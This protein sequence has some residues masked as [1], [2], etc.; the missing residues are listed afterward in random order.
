M[1]S[2]TYN[3][4]KDLSEEE[5]K[6]LSISS[7]KWFS[8]PAGISAID[9]ADSLLLT[10]DQIMKIMEGFVFRGLGTINENVELYCIKLD[11]ENT[12][13]DFESKKV[14][15]HIFF[16]SKEVLKYYFYKSKLAKEDISEYVK[17]LHLGG[18]Q[19]SLSFFNEEVLRKYFDH[20]ELYEIDD[21]MAG[22][23][24]CTNGVAEENEDEYIHVRYGKKKINN[25]Y[26]AITAILSD[27]AA[28]SSN[29]QKYW[30]S[31]EIKECILDGKDEN[32]NKF[33]ERNFEGE[34]V[35]YPNPINDVTKVLSEYNRVF[36]EPT[37]YVQIENIHLRPP[38]ENT[39]KELCN[40][41]SELYKLIGPDNIN[42][43]VLKEYLKKRFQY[44]DSA[45][46]HFESQKALSVLQIFKLFEESITSNKALYE[47]IEIIK[48]YR[49]SA[50]HKILGKDKKPE[51]YTMKF[52]EICQQYV[53]KANE[54]LGKII[55]IE[56]SDC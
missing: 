55:A 4:L 37:L 40:S 3:P 23:R 54:L 25:G 36:A 13:Q 24:V 28:M 12:T 50:D 56:K 8:N 53:L 14:I 7:K 34:W 21:S 29:E 17:R 10:N 35:E 45:L 18:S 43:Q 5:K 38:V 15:T 19:I 52:Y 22:G 32:F 48:S 6:V 46:I 30:S 47:Q 39:D 31:F 1:K 49:I 20:P 26:T 42:I 16:P 2:K 33:F 9:I 27:L 44:A 11:F 41:C 51:K